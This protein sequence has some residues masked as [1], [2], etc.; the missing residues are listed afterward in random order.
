MDIITNK[1]VMCFI[2]SIVSHFPIFLSLWIW[3]A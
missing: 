3:G 1:N 2:N